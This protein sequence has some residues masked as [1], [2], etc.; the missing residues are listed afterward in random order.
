MQTR[1]SIGDKDGKRSVYVVE[2]RNWND[3]PWYPTLGCFRTH[4]EAVKDKKE[5]YELLKKHNPRWIRK[6]NFRI[7]LYVRAE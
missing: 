1:K 3:R 7:A 4:R 2:I 5:R 6:R